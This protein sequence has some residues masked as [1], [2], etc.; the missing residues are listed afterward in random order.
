MSREERL[1]EESRWQ[2]AC[3]N[4][5]KNSGQSS[6]LFGI[7]R[8]FWALPIIPGLL[9]FALQA[10]TLVVSDVAQRAVDRGEVRIAH[11]KKVRTQT[12]H[13]HFG[14]IGEGVADCTAKDEH[15]DLL[16]QSGNVRVPHKRLGAFIQK[17]DPVALTNYNL[18][19]RDGKAMSVTRL[20][21]KTTKTYSWGSFY[22][23]IF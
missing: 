14:D 4:G 6:I 3:W 23:F 16:V 11:V 18:R 15:P 1:P 5:L 17:V 20:V 2:S 9:N 21:T 13:W 10:P 12:A 7:F 8:T 19:G 22:S